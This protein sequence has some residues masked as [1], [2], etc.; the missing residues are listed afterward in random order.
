MRRIIILLILTVMTYSAGNAGENFITICSFD[1]SALGSSSPQKDIR[2]I[3]EI[4]GDFDLSVIQDVQDNGGA[5]KI[6]AIVDSLNTISGRKY[7]YLLIPHAGRGFPG[8]EGYA[9]IFSYPVEVDSTYSPFY[10][11]RETEVSYGRT[12]GWAAFKAGNFDFILASVHLHWSNL[13]TR[14]SEIA[15]IVQWFNDFSGKSGNEEKDLIIAGVTQRFGN[16][17]VS[18]INNRATAYHQL[19]DDPG[20]AVVFRLP[21]CEFLPSPDSKEA[22]DD[23]GSTTVSDNNNMIY[24]EIMISEGVFGEFGDSPAIL[25]SSIGIVAFDNQ[26]EYS[27]L[28]AADISD[29][30]SDHRPVFARFRTDLTD[31]DGPGTLV[32]NL[33]TENSLNISNNPNPFNATTLIKFRLTC[34]GP[35]ELDIFNNLGQKVFT[36][37]KNIDA[38]GDNYLRWNPENL[39]GGIYLIRL[40]TMSGNSWGKMLYLK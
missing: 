17:T 5:G 38:A 33:P 8:Y 35:V 28:A 18:Q 21:F 10:G 7:E 14:E 27:G 30:V 19:L 31:D 40:K 11:F 15:D 23:S 26:P 9:Y 22:P 37:S 16:Y 3:A 24:D 20:Y 29:L 6:S 1:V 12:P 2:K 32:E 34:G 36:T 4:L 39:S 25:G 13:E